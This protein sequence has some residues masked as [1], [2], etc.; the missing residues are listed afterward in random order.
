MQ[1]SY[2][3]Y[4]QGTISDN[5]FLY[6]SPGIPYHL[7]TTSLFSLDLPSN[8]PLSLLILVCNTEP[9]TTSISPLYTPINTTASLT[10]TSK[11]ALHNPSL[12]PPTTREKREAKETCFHHHQSSSAC[13]IIATSFST[14][15]CYQSSVFVATK[16][17]TYGKV[18]PPCLLLL[19]LFATTITKWAQVTVQITAGPFYWIRGG[20]KTS[21][22]NAVCFTWN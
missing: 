13:S 21:G 4:R 20:H 3:V 15:Y 14:F 18:S 22:G 16:P 2:C 17:S 5:L 7:P 6:I 10:S 1:D 12:A 11:R 8:P 9:E 19:L